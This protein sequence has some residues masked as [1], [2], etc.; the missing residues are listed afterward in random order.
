MASMAEARDARNDRISIP[1]LV[2]AL[3]ADPD[4]A[5]ARTIVGQGVSLDAVRRVATACLPEPANE[6]PELIP[7]DSQTQKALQLSFREALRLADDNV[8]SHHILL[9]VLELEDGTGV[10]AGLGVAKA[11][12]DDAIAGGRTAER[13]H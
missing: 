7:F 10:L 1:H 8:D 5:A 4:D 6:V 2:L 12:V 3:T 9:A 11:T 13:D